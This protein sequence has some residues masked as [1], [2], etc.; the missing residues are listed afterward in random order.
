M[1]DCGGAMVSTNRAS[2]STGTVA[3]VRTMTDAPT[4]HSAIDAFWTATGGGPRPTVPL[5]GEV[6]PDRS[7]FRIATAAVAACS[8]VAAALVE[9]TGKH[10]A[11]LD[12]SL[13]LASFT[14]HVRR[15]GRP[16]P[17][18]APLSGTYR[19]ADDRFIQ[20]HCNFPHHAGGVAQRLGV[21]EDRTAFETAVAGWDAET[22]EEELIAAGLV[23]AAYRTLDQWSLHPHAQ[24]VT[25]LPLLDWEVLATNDVAVV[26]GHP[27]SRPLA[28]VRVLDCSRVLAGP[29]AGQTLA[30]LGADVIRVGADHLPVVEIGVLTTGTSKR[31][32]SV[33]LRAT[34]GRAQL[35]DLLR[36]A[37]LLIDAFRPGALARWGFDPGE[38][39]TLA[40]QTSVV[41]ISAFD[42]TGPWAGRRGFDSIVQSTT[43]LALAGAELTHSPTPVH[44]PVQVLDYCTGM[45]AAAAA[46]RALAYRRDRAESRLARLSLLRTRDWLVE[47]GDPQPFDPAAITPA[48]DQVGVIDSDF[49][50]LELVR[51]F[52]GQWAWGPRTLGSSPPR[53]QRRPGEV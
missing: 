24:A 28:G 9:L 3:H 49:G 51:P 10:P 39:A 31:N 23:G 1:A 17:R 30:N 12:P 33:D 7:A 20:L 19:T 32:T 13:A 22:L 11:P 44:L 15:D 40:P 14:T 6:P 50:E 45:F 34:E 4:W 21:P 27:G 8:A 2:R 38:I 46:I 25:G 48:R 47:L 5:T 35:V 41:Q 18:W 26:P 29:V 43:G 52:I 42:W 53:W 16:V 36:D 37:D